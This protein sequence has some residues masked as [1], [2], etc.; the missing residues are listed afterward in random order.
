M[1]KMA[2]NELYFGQQLE[3]NEVLGKI[4]QVRKSDVREISEDL[5]RSEHIGLTVLG[6][7]D[8]DSFASMNLDL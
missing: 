7:V 3:M 2:M 4:E 8:R 6:D 5:F 1:S